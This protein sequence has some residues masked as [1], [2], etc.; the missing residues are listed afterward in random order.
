MILKVN[1]KMKY[2]GTLFCS[3]KQNICVLIKTL[4]I[5]SFYGSS[6]KNSI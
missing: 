1:G 2:A 5:S 3:K 4:E 6:E